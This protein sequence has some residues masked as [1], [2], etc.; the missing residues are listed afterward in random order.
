MQRISPVCVY[1]TQTVLSSIFT[2]LNCELYGMDDGE[3]CCLSR[4]RQTF[5]FF[6]QG[7]AVVYMIRVK[8]IGCIVNHILFSLPSPSYQ[9]C[10]LAKQIP[11]VIPYAF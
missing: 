8:G 2:Q 1:M 11:V 10:T 9:N 4:G 7:V 3:G 6:I 5:F